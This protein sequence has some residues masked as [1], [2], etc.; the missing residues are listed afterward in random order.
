V[1]QRFEPANAAAPELRRAG[2][3]PR[4][5][6]EAVARQASGWFGAL[7]LRG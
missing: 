7:E 4:A 1:L 6:L 3:Y 5:A 2:P